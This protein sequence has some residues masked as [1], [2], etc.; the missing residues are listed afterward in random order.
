[1]LCPSSIQHIGCR[2]HDELFVIQAAH[3]AGSFMKLSFRPQ[4]TSPLAH[5]VAMAYRSL[6]VPTSPMCHWPARMQRCRLLSMHILKSNKQPRQTDSA[7]S[8][9]Y[10]ALAF[11]RS[12]I[13]PSHH[14]CCMITA[15]PLDL[16]AASLFLSFPFPLSYLPFPSSR[17][18]PHSP[19][20]CCRRPR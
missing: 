2:A 17:L 18:P 6:R 1:V 20:Q 9:N 16:F 19:S 14:F 13:S 10:T 4:M 3:T 8:H 5:P 7:T 11:P 15:F 12:P